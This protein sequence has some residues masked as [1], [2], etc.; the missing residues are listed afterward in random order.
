MTNPASDTRS[1]L[2][3]HWPEA[4]Y[5]MQ[6]RKG[7]GF[8]EAAASVPY[9]ARLGITH[10][11]ASP[12]LMAA[13]GSTHG[14]D[15]I[16]H[17]RLNPELGTPEEFDA[18]MRALREAPGGPLFH[19]L[20]TVP[21]HAGV[22]TNLNPWWND[23]LEHG[24]AGKCGRYFDI[25]WRGSPRESMRDR[26][27]LPVLGK[28]YAE[29][30]EAGELRLT[31]DAAQ[32]RLTLHY[33]ERA[34]PLDPRS[35]EPI[36]RAAAESRQNAATPFADL[37]RHV[38]QIPARSE[39]E[40]VPA[41]NRRRLAAELYDR[42][43]RLASEDRSAL[44]TA[45]RDLHGTASDPRS[46]DRF[47]ELLQNQ[48]Y[49]LAY[50]RIASDEINYRRFFD[51][52]DLAAIRMELPEV[53]NAAHEL[54]FDL[55]RRGDLAGLRID[56]P[57][58]LFDPRQYLERLQERYRR[59]GGKGELYV[60][61]EKI[62][63]P[64]EHLRSDWP[65]AGTS[66]Y[67][68]LNKINGLFVD[69]A[70]ERP[71]TKTYADWLGSPAH[72]IDFH[73]LA[74]EKKKLILDR[75]LASELTMLTHRLDLLAQRFRAARDFTLR[76]LRD[77][78]R[79][80]IACFDIYRTYITAA[81]VGEADAAAITRAID[82]ARRHAP[83]VEPALFDFLQRMLL[84]DY[85]QEA[86][87]EDRAAQRLWV[88]RFQQLTS[89]VMAKG[90]E[91][92]AFY[93]YHRLISL[94]EVGGEPTRFGTAPE[95]LHRY[96]ADRAQRWPCALSALST[97]DTKRSEDIR[98]RLHVLSEL[99]DEWARAIAPLRPDI[100]AAS[101]HP[102][103]A[104]LLLQTLL[105]AWPVE[106][107][108]DAARETFAQRITAYMIK[109]LREGKDRSS[110]TD[111]DSAYEQRVAALAQRLIAGRFTETLGR[112]QQTAARLGALTSLSQTLLRLCA[113][114]VPDTYQ[115]T[116]FFDDSL[117]D[118]DNRRPVDYDARRQSLDSA[119]TFAAALAAQNWNAAKQSLVAACLHLRRK[120][121]GLFTTGAYFPAQAAGSL[122]DHLFAFGRQLNGQRAI[123]AVPRLFASLE[124]TT[125]NTAA[126]PIADL[127]QS[128]DL[129]LPA[130][131]GRYIHPLTHEHLESNDGH[132]PAKSLFTKLPVCVL[133]SA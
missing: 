73:E 26:V 23:V 54:P 40:P 130:F 18:W 51:I 124:R 39:C 74:I 113:P 27:L 129:H 123:I 110:W 70:G 91:D 75:A 121:P 7:F 3:P 120:H 68:F 127:W 42:L 112:L 53:F 49:R 30:L 100:D 132:F 35:Y 131:A 104:Y 2:H 38:Q 109:A 24:P 56:H 11:Y 29:V 15:V 22:A 16:D 25:S 102:N 12:Y 47:D 95:E 103:D 101:V 46:W 133:L 17:S 116:E 6:L 57:D 36:L 77:A 9:L 20:D 55:I 96:L 69:P 48:P 93:L 43:A 89:P 86:A 80:T 63:A 28:P 79:E 71:L 107:L 108:T 31:F 118:P 119:P 88:G 84:L 61:V 59:D 60:V 8:R 76:S 41:E 64:D 115:G 62:L 98:A 97:H 13:Q 126:L 33:Y 67:D 106:P 65:V 5:R 66:G 32:G 105:G 122:A 87:A 81:P 94:N 83:D 52:N 4:T 128:T 92:T 34:F 85:P 58:G 99:P 117:V 50:W 37:V 45:V 125:R 78:L 82:K 72:A 10:V 44:E 114:G 21:N 19:I 111:P 14:Y 90:V 1:A